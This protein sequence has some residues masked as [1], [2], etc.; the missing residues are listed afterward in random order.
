[1]VKGS[2]LPRLHRGRDLQPEV[3]GGTVPLDPRF[4]KCA[5]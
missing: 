4:A 5:Q 2:E 1:M 3:E